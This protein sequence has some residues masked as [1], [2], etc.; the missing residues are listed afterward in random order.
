MGFPGPT[1]PQYLLRIGVYPY[2][3]GPEKKCVCF[4]C[5]VRMLPLAGRCCWMSSIN[6]LERF[7]ARWD[8]TQSLKFSH[9]PLYIHKLD[10]IILS[11]MPF[12]WHVKSHSQKPAGF[13]FGV[14]RD[15][16]CQFP[17][18]TVPG[19]ALIH[20]SISGSP[21]RSILA[22]HQLT[23]T[24]WGCVNST[25]CCPKLV[26]YVVVFVGPILLR[27]ESGWVIAIP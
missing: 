12:F 9:H 5:I 2:E 14:S 15:R 24:C 4:F 11:P 18:F 27:L 22:C 23:A 6:L 26:E 1:V 7:T 21:H 20:G 17:S 13:I 8:S 19:H 16:L 3:N 25:T 10:F